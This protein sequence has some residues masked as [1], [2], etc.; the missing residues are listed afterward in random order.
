VE[1]G[2]V[3]SGKVLLFFALLWCAAQLTLFAGLRIL[4]PIRNE[5]AIFLLH[6]VAFAGFAIV[7]GTSYALC[8]QISTTVA[9]GAVCLNAIYCLSFLEL[10]SLTEG[11]YSIGMLKSLKDGPQPKSIIAMQAI[12]VGDRKRD[13]R[14]AGL[15][16]LALINN[17]FGTLAL[18]PRGRVVTVAIVFLRALANFRNPG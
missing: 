13:N 12:A 1:K 18:T 14:I 16:R 5:G 8:P 6:V 15:R 11:G 10:W 7:A 17:E 2:A 9:L 4:R 3:V